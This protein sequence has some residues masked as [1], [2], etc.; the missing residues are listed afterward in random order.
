M[1]HVTFIEA[2]KISQEKQEKSCR[3]KW[4][5]AKTTG[6]TLRGRKSLRWEGGR[7]VSTADKTPQQDLAGAHGYESSMSRESWQAYLGK[8]RWSTA[9][10]AEAPMD[11][12]RGPYALCVSCLSWYVLLAQRSEA[13]CSR[14]RWQP[15]A[16]VLLPVLAAEAIFAAQ[17]EC[18]RGSVRSAHD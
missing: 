13:Y 5:G 1:V 11:A 3:Q 9:R 15:H 6:S 17:S 7:P 8:R 4:T 10:L 14:H 16:W 12:L 18:R 2:A